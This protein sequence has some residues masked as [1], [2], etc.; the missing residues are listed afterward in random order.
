MGLSQGGLAALINSIESKPEKAV[1]ASGFSFYMKN[2]YRS[3]HDQIVI[4]GYRK[5]YSVDSVKAKISELSTR[6]LFTW[7][8]DE[9]GMYGEDARNNLTKSFLEP[10]TNV[11]CIIHPL[12]HIYYEPAINEFLS[13]D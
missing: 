2:P 4:P 6:F 13:K 7:G 10:L 8:L 11:K 5:I 1:I 9:R 3:S 12:G